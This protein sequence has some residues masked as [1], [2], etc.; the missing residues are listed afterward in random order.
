MSNTLP[1][2]QL[3]G[4]FSD[5]SNDWGEYMNANLLKLTSMV[6]CNVVS[7][8]DVKPESPANGVYLLSDTE[9]TNPNRIAVYFNNTWTHYM[10]QRGWLIYHR[11]ESTFKFWNGVS[12]VSI[13]IHSPLLAS[14]AALDATDGIVAMIDGEFEKISLGAGAGHILTPTFADTLYSPLAHTHAEKLMFSME[15]AAASSEVVFRHIFNRSFNFA[16]DF[17]GILGRAESCAAPYVL[18]VWLQTDSIS[19][20]EIKGTITIETNGAITAQTVSNAAFSAPTGSIM[21]ITGPASV[22]SITGLVV[23]FVSV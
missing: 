20:F 22:T 4:N 8:L 17:A 9:A 6:Q 11:L 16:G 12:W 2:L 21:K 13:P 3:R 1:H 19:S 10:P 5:R 15:A 7:T 14:I 18:T 23:S